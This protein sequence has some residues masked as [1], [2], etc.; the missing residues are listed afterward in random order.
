MQI[1]FKNKARDNEKAERTNVREYF[2]FGS[3]RSQLNARCIDVLS[4]S[5]FHGF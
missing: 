1:A 4:F 3:Q 5:L 2:E